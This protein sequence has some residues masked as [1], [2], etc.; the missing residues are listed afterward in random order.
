VL[1]RL[2]AE[3]ISLAAPDAGP[4]NPQDPALLAF[5]G[6]ATEAGPPEAA[7][8][9]RVDWLDAELSRVLGLLRECLEGTPVA[10]SSD[11]RL[12]L[13]V[14]RRRARVSVEPGWV[15]VELDLDEVS[16]AVRRAGLDLDPGHLPWLGVVVRFRY[17]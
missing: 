16:T 7:A 14:L 11:Q 13:T 3:L 4:V 10:E 17:A 12:L 1:H 9:G 15:D 6:L 5:C 2:G 8:D